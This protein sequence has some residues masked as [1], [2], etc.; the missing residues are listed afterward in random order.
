MTGV[1]VDTSD[2]FVKL[3]CGF[4]MVKLVKLEKLDCGFEMLML[5]GA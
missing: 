5:D 2:E 1:G 4:V 3:D